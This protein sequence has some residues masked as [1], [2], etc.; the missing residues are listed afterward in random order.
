MFAYDIK[1]GWK[2]IED[3]LAN[4]SEQQTLQDDLGIAGYCRSPIGR[5][6]R[7][8]SFFDTEIYIAKEAKEYLY[9]LVIDTGMFCEVIAISNFPSLVEFLSKISVISSGALFSELHSVNE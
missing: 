7:L 9:I 4:L 5:L 2:E 8:D 6:G 3:F 1:Y